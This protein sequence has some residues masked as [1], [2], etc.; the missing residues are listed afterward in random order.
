L[1]EVVKVERRDEAFPYVVDTVRNFISLGLL[2]I[3]EVK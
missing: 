1:L 2:E 3:K